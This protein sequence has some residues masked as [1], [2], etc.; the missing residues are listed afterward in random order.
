MGWGRDC[1]DCAKLPLWSLQWGRGPPPFFW[2]DF[3]NSC[4]PNLSLI[5]ALLVLTLANQCL[6]LIPWQSY[7]YT[8]YCG[9]NGSWS[10]TYRHSCR[11]L[12]WA[13]S[14]SGRLWV[15]CGKRPLVGSQVCAKLHQLATTPSECCPTI[16]MAMT[17][18]DNPS[19]P[20]PASFCLS[21][22]N[23]RLRWVHST[24]DGH[25]QP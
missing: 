22:I 25:G 6:K 12:A 10:P 3:E 11:N 20:T 7:I 8:F 18:L 9:D 15:F 14:M 21:A 16:T 24:K 23:V 1:K 17:T 5:I 13:S 4:Y 19:P 2:Q